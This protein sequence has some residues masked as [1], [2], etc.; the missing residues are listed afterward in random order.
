MKQPQMRRRLATASVAGVL[1]LAVLPAMTGRP[2]PVLAAALL[3]CM[4]AAAIAI[5]DLAR[6]LIPDGYTA[7]IAMV[8]AVLA[9]GEGGWVRLGAAFLDAALLGASLLL[10]TIIYE[11]LRGRSGLGLGDVKLLTASALLVG[12]WGVG[13][14][15]TL[16]SFAALA[17]A[18][19]RAVRRGRPLRAVSR[20]PFATFLAPAM[21]LVW[22]WGPQ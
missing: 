7:A 12:L 17:F 5:E 18:V 21:V 6:M 9:Y 4:L 16:A 15:I 1:I 22:A 13:M 11:R 3:L 10:L 2:L 20:I 14:Q 19:I 8:G